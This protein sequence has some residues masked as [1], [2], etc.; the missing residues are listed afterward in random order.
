MAI[1]KKSKAEDD[2]ETIVEMALRLWKRDEEHWR[3]IYKEAENDLDFLSAKPGA[4]WVK[5]DFNK[6]NA[7]GRPALTLDQ[8]NQFVHQ[9]ANDIRETTPF[10]DV[11]PRTEGSEEFAEAVKWWI[12][13]IEYKSVADDV[14]DT[15]ALNAIKCSIGF[16]YVNHDYSD[17]ETFDQEL[18]INRVV[19]PLAI[20]LDSNSIECDGRDAGHGFMLDVMTVADYKKKY[21]GKSAVPFESDRSSKPLE[22]GDIKLADFFYI[23]N[24]ES[25]ISKGGK[26]RKIKT[27]KVM[28]YRLSGADVL[29]TT[30][31]P[32]KYI[33]II[34]VYGEECWNKGER[35][36][37]SLIRGGK[38]GQM[39]FNLWKSMEAELLM[40]Q[41]QAPIMAAE[42]QLAGY[43]DGYINPA[44]LQVLT[45]K[46]TDLD[47][48]VVGAPQ[49]LA[50]PQIPTGIVNAARQSVDDIKSSMGLYSA[51]LGQRSN[52]TSG[53]AIQNRQ[54]EGS[55]ATYHFKDNL[56]RSVAQVGRV[57]ESARKDVMDTARVV[58]GIDSEDNV[59]YIGINGKLV[60]GQEQ[61]FDFTSGDFDIR[62]K[63]GS[64][65]ASK[66][67]ESSALL[68]EIIKGNP[69]MMSVLGDLWAKNLDVAGS[70]ALHD[71]LE[72][73]I[74]PQLKSVSEGE[75][76]VDA[77]KEQLK[78]DVAEMQH[79]LEQASQAVES[80][81]SEQEAKL[82]AEVNKMQM[83]QQEAQMDAQLR[84][85]ELAIKKDELEFK[86]E[87]AARKAEIDLADL[88]LRA[89]E[90]EI[91]AIPQLET[92]PVEYAEPQEDDEGQLL[93]RVDR[94]RTK[95]AS[96]QQAKEQEM[97]EKAAAREQ[98][99]MEK[100]AER[101]SREAATMAVLSAIG[102]LAAAITKPKTVIRDANN[103]II[104]VR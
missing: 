68:G 66:R 25:E 35:F 56:N 96:Q 80:K 60:K 87:D 92:E 62:V 14:Y 55:T 89:R 33:P 93:A 83:Q 57:L 65:F 20:Y 36:L 21:P 23:E 67:E 39:M 42:G 97:M 69:E 46:N 51:A 79:L 86:R 5:E 100:A 76:E 37:K 88:Q 1:V 22:D 53:I 44:L 99:L 58:R 47:G 61:S 30:V 85:E 103:D 78:A 10:I 13:G 3:A 82:Q 91:A 104:G 34:P 8:M 95:K 12:K 54:E 4:Q 63:T 16:I 101:E 70:E 11:I 73:L 6:R 9:V 81:Q 90:I 43:E 71:R 17:D 32:G 31:F 48:N 28:R 49:R 72:K 26:T 38:D 74:P 84:A 98:D 102:N 94:I 75:S 7:V 77:E 50:P 29:E 41:P 18:S 64:N 45:Y 59:K 24:T 27:K 2:K 15:A 19:N 52:E 40:K